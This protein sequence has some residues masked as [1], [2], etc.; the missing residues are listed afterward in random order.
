MLGNLTSVVQFGFITGT[1]LFAI[2]SIADRISSSSVFFAS[3][4]IAAV[5]NV[6]VIW[7]AKSVS[8]LFALRFVTGFF[9]AG[10]YP[11]G[12]KIASDWYEK[13]LGK[14][15]GWLVGALV[16]GTAFPHLLKSNLYSLPWKQVLIF[17]SIF[18]AVGGLLIL[19]FVGDGP[20]RKPASRFQPSA[21][22]QIFRSADFRAA[23]FGYFGHMWELYTFWAFTPVMLMLYTNSRAEQINI[24]FWSFVIIAVGSLSCVAGG[25]ASQKIG[26]SRV[27]F[28]ALVCSGLCCL[29]SAVL[30]K[31][32]LLPFVLVMLLWG[33]SV[34]ADSP[35]FST[36]VA[37]TAMPEYKG[38]AL[39]IVT[40]IGFAITIGSIQLLNWAFDSWSN[41]NAVFLLLAPGPLLGLSFLLRLIKQKDGKL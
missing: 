26:S 41:K 17:T 27:A 30:F 37:Q 39:T 3:S 31:V 4:L 24:P 6:S 34:I 11:V 40:S 32:G 35:Q 5:A 12:M 19:L 2:F 23:A 25:Y 7:L 28:Y 22:I 29:A 18:A 36:L 1:L 20:Y 15:L 33:I 38:T 9:L 14:A 8:I 10:I 16:L 13:G 21:V